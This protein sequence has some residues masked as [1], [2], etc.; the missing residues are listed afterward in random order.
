MGGYAFGMIPSLTSVILEEGLTILG[1][2]SAFAYNQLTNITISESVTSIGEEA[3]KN[4]K[5]PD[6]DAIT[7]KGDSTRFDSQWTGIGFPTK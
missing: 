5:F 2:D 6:A 7:V 3:F 1:Y 4:N